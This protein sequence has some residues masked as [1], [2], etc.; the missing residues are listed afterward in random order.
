[1]EW[2]AVLISITMVATIVIYWIGRSTDP[3]D[4]IFRPLA[5]FVVLLAWFTFA[6]YAGYL[7]SPTPATSRREWHKSG[8]E[9]IAPTYPTV[10]STQTTQLPVNNRQL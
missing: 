9:L 5:L 3:R 2:F 8:D 4:T 7:P 6:C 1:M 10:P